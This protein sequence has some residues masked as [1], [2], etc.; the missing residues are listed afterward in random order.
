MK[1]SYRQGC[2]V[3]G[4][5]NCVAD[6]AVPNHQINVGGCELGGLAGARTF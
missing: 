6:D 3:D 5:A 2:I 4:L 1:V